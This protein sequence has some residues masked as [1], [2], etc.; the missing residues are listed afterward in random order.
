MVPVQLTTMTTYRSTRRSLLLPFALAL[1]LSPFAAAQTTLY[2]DQNGTGLGLGGSGAWTIQTPGTKF[3]TINSAGA[4]NGGET[5]AWVNN[6]TPDHAVFQGTA[7]TVTVGAAGDTA[8]NVTNVT[9]GVGGYTI[10]AGTLSTLTLAATSV[11]DTGAFNATISVGLAGAGTSLTKNGSG[12][13]TLSGSSTFTGP[14]TISA[15]TVAV[16]ANNALGTTTAT[17]VAPGA[18]IDFQGGVTYSTAESLNVNGGTIAASSGINSFAGSVALGTGGGTANIA[19]ELTMSGAVTGSTSLTKSGAGLLTLSNTANTYS[20]GTIISAGTL[21]L[22]GNLTSAANGVTV[23]N[24]ATLAGT[25]SIA[26]PTTLSSGGFVSPA[27]GGIGTLSLAS[28]TFNG[29]GTLSLG[30]GSGSSSDTVAVTGAFTKGSA[31]TYTIDFGNTG[32]S[33]NTYTLV[34]F[35]SGNTTFASNDFTFA[36]I[37]SGLTGTFAMSSTDLTFTTTAIPEPATYAALVGL[38]VLG[39][40][41][42]RRRRGRSAAAVSVTASV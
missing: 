35:G 20:G 33:G 14:L 38:G 2:W 9:F 25:G 17:T 36:N 34:T 26:G 40:A 1:S 4:A 37:A 29:G 10:S 12:T 15:G 22:T 41:V 16:T 5:Q 18:T 8:I 6:A 3:W 23:G 31:G 24:G 39:M 11:I 28:L 32:T 30:L 13:L 19:G 7:G 21:N 27:S 42:Y